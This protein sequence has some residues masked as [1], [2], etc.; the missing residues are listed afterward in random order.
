MVIR[1]TA[2]TNSKVKTDLLV[3]DKEIMPLSELKTDSLFILFLR[4]K[5]RKSVV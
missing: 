3:G 5:D 2:E 1:I 4:G